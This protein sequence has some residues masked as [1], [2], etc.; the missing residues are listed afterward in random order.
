MIKEKFKNSSE[1]LYNLGVAYLNKRIYDK[2]N[3]YL[4]ASYELKKSIFTQFLII[5]SE[6][7][8]I[9][10]RRAAIFTISD[11][12]K[13][14][15]DKAY[16]KLTTP[17]IEH[18]F[19]KAVVELKTE[20]WHVRL[21][22]LLFID[23]N[24]VLQ[25][26]E[27]LP[28][29]IKN[30]PDFKILIADTFILTNERGN[31]LLVL[32]EVYNEY[33]L[34][35]ILLKIL[36]IFISERENK[37][38]LEIYS[39]LKESDFDKDGHVAATIIEVI[40][41]VEGI[42]RANEEAQRFIKKGANPFFLY[43]SLGVIN[44]ENGNKETGL[45]LLSKLVQ[46]I[47]AD[48]FPPRMIFADDLLKYGCN[49]LAL[50][51][52]KPFIQYNENA[53]SKYIHTLISTGGE[54][55]LS[56]AERL[57]N[58]K[59]SNEEKTLQ[60]LKLKID[61]LHKTGK[62]HAAIQELDKLIELD[63]SVPNAYNAVVL[64]ME[65]GQR[66]FLK[67][68]KIL[69]QDENN[70]ISLITSALC[71]KAEGNYTHAEYLSYKS[72]AKNKDAVN[73]AAI[74]FVYGNYVGINLYPE[75][76]ERGD[77]KV[78][79]DEIEVNS[80]F[81]LINE[82]KKIW[83]AI[84]SDN[85]LFNEDSSLK[86][87]GATHFRPNDPKVIGL[88][89]SKLNST[90]IF[91]EEN[92]TLSQIITLKKRAIQYCLEIYTANRPDSK[93]LKGVQIDQTHPMSSMLPMLFEM[94][95]QQKD[96]LE[97]YNLKNKIG[98]P[99]W[100]I[101]KQFGHNLLDGIFY[102]LNKVNQIFYAGEVVLFNPKGTT[103]VLSPSSILFLNILNVFDLL[104][105]ISSDITISKE[106]Y[107]YF[108]AEL[109][110]INVQDKRVKMTVGIENGK[111]FVSEITEEHF[112]ARREFFTKIVTGLGKLKI[113]DLNIDK[114][115]LD[116]HAQIIKLVTLQDF[117]AI[118]LVDSLNGIYV[119]DDL[120]VRKTSNI[121][122]EKKI[123]TNTVSILYLLF[124]EDLEL[125]FDQLDKLAKSNYLY[126]YNDL[127]L[128]SIIQKIVKEHRI[129][130]PDTLYGRLQNLI[131]SSLSTPQQL[132]YYEPILFKVINVIYRKGINEHTD[133][134]IKSI[135]K[136]IWLYY[137]LNIINEDL[138][139][140]KLVSISNEE[141]DYKYFNSVLMAI[142]KGNFN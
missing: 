45:E 78:D 40:A 43:H 55:N 17:E 41:E 121:L 13:A 132:A 27:K 72:L 112:K 3:E 139:L 56:E 21:A 95:K 57:L 5:V 101:S 97:E 32:Q 124:K 2:A 67:Y 85:T 34:P 93:F 98:I 140:N 99:L 84:D 80:A 66:D 49:N 105:N 86:F 102:I 76:P 125:L 69:E 100:L 70:P 90:L 119:C 87:I 103:L 12:E 65:L 1:A 26:I 115:E 94:E 63:P 24:K 133:Y 75:I 50:D 129:L 52:L 18:F 8:P 118:Y 35:E 15:L 106:T 19:E 30:K 4:K 126:V 42:N 134:I 9:T 131:H 33:K 61:L 128:L 130:G 28:P 64:K 96:L 48:N 138:L 114:N 31:A 117:I 109:E 36:N 135:I 92:F 91:E 108:L 46:N 82:T 81:E 104:K 47:P 79:L 59:L 83:I 62:K 6:I 136:E 123:T 71:Y 58:E 29:E 53:V 10:Q 89:G 7:H 88:I 11:A 25:Q 38:V 20:Y 39:G 16:K 51:C 54:S 127:L 120:V 68:A 14:I 77:E 110:K 73:D 74:D 37:K 111:P 142:K 23:K 22:I 44:L 113:I 141:K 137:S 116:K 60:W 107:N 122:L